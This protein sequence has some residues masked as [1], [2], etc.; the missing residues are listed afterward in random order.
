MFVFN[1]AVMIKQDSW[2]HSYLI[3]R[4]ETLGRGMANEEQDFHPQQHGYRSVNPY[5]GWTW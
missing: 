5:Y 4:G 1:I 2:G 3:V